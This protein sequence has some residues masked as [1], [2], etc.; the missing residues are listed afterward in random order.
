MKKIL[1]FLSV[2]LLIILSFVLLSSNIYAAT[3]DAYMIV[4]NPGQDASIEMNIGWH[5]NVEN[6]KSYIVYTTKDD[7][8]WKNQKQ[9]FGSYEY[10]DVFDGVFSKDASGKSIYQDVK[11]LDYSV[12]LTDLLPDTEYMY[13]VGQNVL[14]DVQYFKT[15]GSTEFSFAWISDFHTY[16]PIPNR[17]KSAMNMIQKLDEYNKG[18]DF[19]FSTGDEMAWG[20]SYAHWLDL[21]NEKYHKNYMW[22]GVIGNHDFMDGSN[23]KNKND[24]F[25]SV[26]AYPT[27]GYEGEEGVC[28]YFTYSN[29]LFITMNN[30]TQTSAAEVEK[31]QKWFEEVVTR[32]P[33]QY[34]IVAQHYQWF[35]GSSG[36]FNNS[37]GYGRWKELFDK[38]NVDLAIAGNNHI[39]VRSKPIY[40]DKV[41]T[42]YRYGTTYIQSPS[43]DNE[44]GSDMGTLTYNKDIIAHRFSEGGKTVGGIIVNVSEE[45]IKVELLNRNG[46]LLDSTEIKARRDVYPMNN[47]DKESFTSKISYLPSIKNDQSILSFDNS[48]IGYVKDIQV[49]KGNEVLAS[50]IFKRDLDTLLTVNNLPKDATTELDVV[51]TYKDNTTDTVKVNVNTKVLTGKLTEF[52]VDIVNEG[53]KV[54][55][56]NTYTELDEIKVYLNDELVS[57]NAGTISEFIVPTVNKSILD[58]IK[59]EGLINNSVISTK[60]VNYYAPI[61]YLCDGKEDVNDLVLFS[62]E[63]LKLETEGLTEQTQSIYDKIY[64]YDLNND[65]FIDVKDATYMAMYLDKVIS[66]ATLKQFKVT[67][68]DANGNVLDIQYVDAFDDAEISDPTIDGYTF[69]GWDK[70]FT[71][72]TSDIV[73]KAIYSKN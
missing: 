39:Y 7:T 67:F 1:N 19:I 16:A 50:T 37:T 12:L 71:N 41:S 52:D 48:G 4:A 30:E 68:L 18:F 65:G 5:T 6:T 24:Y 27:N 28:Y 20:G 35:S 64:Y 62:E 54:T 44:R 53:Y 72:V 29:V 14:S 66:D 40:Q 45:K 33:A 36:S 9:V 58:K 8:N 70:D 57:T 13:K 22:S 31:A 3:P 42:D 2:I 23:T 32:N 55:F 21:F 56:E 11:F 63:I 25:R 17:L 61:D 34:I 38:Y 69:I 46:E 26:H 10:V 43:S 73:V 49:K 59:I 60:E 51:I 47:F 15:A